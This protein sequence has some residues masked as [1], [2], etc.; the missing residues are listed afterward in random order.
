MKKI[1]SVIFTFIVCVT[2]M[3]CK[4]N[5]VEQQPI[6]SFPGSVLTTPDGI[7]MALTGAYSALNGA[8]GMARGP[9]NILFG[10]I[11]GGEAHKGSTGGDQ[12]QMIEIQKFAVNSG[13]SSVTSNFLFYYDAVYRTNL[14]LSN[15]PNVTGLSDAQK[16]QIAAEARF[17]RGHYMFF[18]KR[19][20]G[21]VP[22][23]DETSID[24]PRVPNTDES[25]N[26]VDAW[27][28]IA[29]DFK[30][31]AEN[32]APTNA[33]KGRAN[34][35]AAVAY[36]GKTYLYMGNHGDN[37]NYALAQAAFNDVIANGVTNSGVK[38]TLNADYHANFNSLTENGPEA[39][40]A[41]QHSVN[42]GSTSN[43]ANSS[44]DLQYISP[45]SGG[46]PGDNRGYGFFY[47]SQWFVNHFRVDANGLPIFDDA[48]RNADKIKS[49]DG[50]PA[51]DPYTPDAGLIDPRLDWSVGRRG[52]PFLDYGQFVPTWV[53]DPAAAGPYLSQKFFTSKAANGLA[54]SR[55]ENNLNIN[56]IRFADVLLMAAEVEAR[57][58]SLD[59]A[60]SYVNQVRG[61]MATNTTSKENWVLLEDG[62]PAANY[63][64]GLYPVGSPQFAS[65]AKALEAIFF[66][67]TLEL[68][69]EGHRAYDAVRFGAED[70]TTDTKELNGY[71]AYESTL[72]GYLSGGV[73]T[74]TPDAIMPIPQQAIDNSFKDGKY[75]LEQNPDY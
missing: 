61:R 72:K 3:S 15:L 34:K 36:L 58:G 57:I 59:L 22:F 48:A 8:G 1:H 66:E 51:A 12:P 7:S 69:L 26:F 31:A 75:T 30:F 54:S 32:L 74:R 65:P 4:D 53:R 17:L 49:D 29:A 55:P 2:L 11:R 73:Y 35:W 52:I 47:P 68:G 39:V 42:D 56:I 20:F 10:S 27:P 44:L 43:N 64:I 18:L 40:F 23:V 21:N 24:D 33:D 19:L 63:K 6:G 67:R 9:G 37:A 60:R 41:V 50:I 38:Y 46:G 14:V 45:Q 16:T 13:N 5:F 25:G 71:I 62:T 70:G 28:A